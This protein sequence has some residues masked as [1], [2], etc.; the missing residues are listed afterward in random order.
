MCRV[1]NRYGRT[2]QF[3]RWK[4]YSPIGI[5]NTTG[6]TASNYIPDCNKYYFYFPIYDCSVSLRCSIYWVFF[7]WLLYLNKKFRMLLPSPLFM[8]IYL[9]YL[10]LRQ[11]F[12]EMLMRFWTVY[13]SIGVFCWGFFVGFSL[14][15]AEK[16][17]WFCWC[18]SKSTFYW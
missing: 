9:H 15:S 2:F 8:N 17:M 13:S 10:L 1:Y 11:P 5:A 3:S 7:I 16:R 4:R 6:K 14:F 12:I 18:L